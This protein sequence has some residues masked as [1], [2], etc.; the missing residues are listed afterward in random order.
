MSA[1]RVL[2]ESNQSFDVRM[3]HKVEA[4]EDV[5]TPAGTFKVF[6]IRADDGGP[7]KS[8]TW[9]SPE[10]RSDMVFCSLIGESGALDDISREVVKDMP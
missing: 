9:W 8:V 2:F 7:Y 6:R 10:I 3:S 1:Y 4:Y 5:T